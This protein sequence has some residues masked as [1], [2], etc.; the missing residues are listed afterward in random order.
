A[1]RGLRPGSRRRPG[2]AAGTATPTTSPGSRAAGGRARRRPAPRPE[3][4]IRSRR[5]GS[6]GVRSSTLDQLPPGREAAADVIRGHPQR[7]LWDAVA[8]LPLFPVVVAGPLERRLAEGHELSGRAAEEA[9][10]GEGQLEVP[11][12]G[13]PA[14]D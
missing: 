10:Q 13:R 4:R 7:V 12:D 3:R 14:E 8:D 5:P 1:G 11:D 9:P 6:R 2:P